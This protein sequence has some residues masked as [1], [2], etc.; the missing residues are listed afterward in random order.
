MYRYGSNGPWI[1]VITRILQ[2]VFPFLCLSTLLSMPPGTAAQSAPQPRKHP[3]SMSIVAPQDAQRFQAAIAEYDAGHASAANPVLLDLATHYSRNAQVQGVTGMSLLESGHAEEAILFL[4]R[5]VKIESDPALEKN[6]ALA[7]LQTNHPAVALPILR[8]L[9]VSASSDFE[10]WF[11]LGQALSMTKQPGAAAAYQHAALLVTS[12]PA[13]VMPTLRY[14]WAVALLTE[15]QPAAALAVLEQL[16]R[17]SDDAALLSLRA[18]AEEKTGAYE[19][20][21]ADYRH[22]AEMEASSTNIQSYGEELLRH[23]S[24]GP[25]ASIF[26]YGLGQY[27]GNDALERDLGVAYFGAN[28]SVKAGDV[29][30]ALLVQ[31]PEDATLADLLGRSCDVLATSHSTGCAQLPA[32]ARSHPGNAPASLY[33]AVALLHQ[34]ASPQTYAEADTFLQDALKAQPGLA[35]AWY[36]MGVLQQARGDWPGSARSLE[37]AV[38]LNPDAAEAHYHLFRAYAH[39]GRPTEAREQLALHQ[40]ASVREKEQ[41]SQRL[42]REV[43]FLP[44]KP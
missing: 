34:S 40:A 23:S 33:A 39:L 43:L 10:T 7:C 37:H 15:N 29:F 20:A 11:A 26:Q 1:S 12:V 27:P 5:A 35:A 32:F 19:A 25:A 24:F 9:S 41:Q 6:L 8:R 16:S 4:E 3:A 13:R 21:L 14:D 28:D 44:G 38:L 42:A 30:G 2:L 17:A 31:H 36:Q 22:T 18:E